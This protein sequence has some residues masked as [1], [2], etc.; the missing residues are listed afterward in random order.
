MAKNQFQ[1]YWLLL[2]FLAAV[3]MCWVLLSLLFVCLSTATT[4]VNITVTKNTILQKQ[5]CLPSV[6]W[7]CWLGSSKGIWPVENWVVGCWHGYLSG[8]T[9]LAHLGSPGK[10]WLNGCVCVKLL[11]YKKQLRLIN[12][13]DELGITDNCTVS[14]S[15]QIHAHT[16]ISLLKVGLSD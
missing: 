6:L 8:F 3:L 15:N 10:G 7:R 9:F 12:L 5:V 14:G 2:A 13:Q 11:F 16:I 4:A 1:D